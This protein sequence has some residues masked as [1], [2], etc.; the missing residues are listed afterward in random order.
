MQRRDDMKK[1]LRKAKNNKKK[2]I[3][4][5]ML[6]TVIIVIL[7]MLSLNVIK[8]GFKDDELVGTWVFD[9]ATTFRFDGKGEGE[10][11]LP[12]K[13]YSFQYEMNTEEKKVSIDFQ[14]EKAEDYIYSYVVD[15]EYLTLY[16]RVEKETF[17]FVL[18]KQEKQQ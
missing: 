10:M 13:T 17:E 5:W 11:I 4:G 7:G 2:R 14:D 6:L 1:K 16:G 12:N 18:K 3:I 9:E 15:E 8:K